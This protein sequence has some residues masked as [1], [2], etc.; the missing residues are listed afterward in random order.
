MNGNKKLP[1]PKVQLCVV[2]IRYYKKLYPDE[3]KINSNLLLKK[4]G[5]VMICN[6]LSKNLLRQAFFGKH[7]VSL[8]VKLA[9]VLCQANKVDDA[10]KMLRSLLIECTNKLEENHPDT[11]LTSLH[12]SSVLRSQN[13]LRQA[14]GLCNW[15]LRVNMQNYGSHH[16][17]TILSVNVMAK[18]LKEYSTLNQQCYLWKRKSYCAGRCRCP[19]KLW[20]ESPSTFL[21]WRICRN[22]VS[23]MEN[24]MMQRRCYGILYRVSQNYP[25]YVI[26]QWSCIWY[27]I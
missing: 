5:C 1:K 27:E 6:N 4:I 15:A 12:L 13:K 11:V 26:I 2:K 17:R 20:N 22:S 8:T 10:E 24:L 21:L 7:R 14:K 3:H 25:R 18:I 9:S 16:T 19:Y 23:G